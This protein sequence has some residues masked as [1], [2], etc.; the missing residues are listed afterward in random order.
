[1]SGD[2][3]LSQGS[4]GRTARKQEVSHTTTLIVLL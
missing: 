4:L 1:M 2:N 3:E